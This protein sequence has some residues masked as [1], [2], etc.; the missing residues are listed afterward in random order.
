MAYHP[1]VMVESDMGKKKKKPV[2]SKP[3][4]GGVVSKIDVQISM[5]PIHP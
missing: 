2:S 1:I 3:I 5:R 4:C